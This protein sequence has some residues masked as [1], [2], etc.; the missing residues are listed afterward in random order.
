MDSNLSWLV[1]Y[2][3]YNWVFTP[4]EDVY[5]R[6]VDVS[7]SFNVF[8]LSYPTRFEV[9]VDEQFDEYWLDTQEHF[10]FRSAMIL[11]LIGPPEYSVL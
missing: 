5:E 7:H 4:V 8:S 2:L 11:A 9:E 10:L 6:K 3:K 1:N